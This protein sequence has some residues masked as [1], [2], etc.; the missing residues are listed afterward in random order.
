MWLFGY[1]FHTRW[2]RVN[3]MGGK[4]PQVDLSVT[5]IPIGFCQIG[6]RPGKP[7]QRPYLGSL[8]VPGPLW[9]Q[10]RTWQPSCL[11]ILIFSTSSE[12]ENLK[13]CTQLEITSC[14]FCFCN[15]NSS[16]QSNISYIGWGDGIGAYNNPRN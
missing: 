8:W 7:H 16:M 1:M 10:S 9:V 12:E 11:L 3:K 4:F 2:Y 5:R 6:L 15:S 14:L 13:T